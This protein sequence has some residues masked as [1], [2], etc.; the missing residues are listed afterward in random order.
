MGMLNKIVNHSISVFVGILIG[1]LIWFAFTLSPAS[2]C[3]LYG[4]FCEPDGVC[5]NCTVI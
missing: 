2:S 3:L 1:L 4:K 5:F